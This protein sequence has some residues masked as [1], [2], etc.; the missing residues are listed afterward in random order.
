MCK[1]YFQYFLTAL[2]SGAKT[3]KMNWKKYPRIV[4]IF[5]FAGSFP[6]AGRTTSTMARMRKFWNST[7]K[8][9]CT[10]WTDNKFFYSR[11]KISRFVWLLQFGI[12]SIRELLTQYNKDIALNNIICN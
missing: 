6:I 8:L 9:L 12:F 3:V 1:F 10:G 4:C 7:I 11:K 5:R 2:L